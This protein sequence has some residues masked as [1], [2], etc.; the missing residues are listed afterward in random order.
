MISEEISKQA[1]KKLGSRLRKQQNSESKIL[2]NNDIKS[3]HEYRIWFKEPMSH[4]FKIVGDISS[5][6]YGSRVITY[7]IKRIESILSKLIRE[8]TMSLTKMGDIV[9]CRCIVNTEENVYKIVELIKQKFNIV[10]ERDYLK[11]PRQSGYQSY[12]LV[13]QLPEDWRTVEIQI[14]TDNNHNWATLLEITDLLYNVKVKEGATHKDLEKFHLLR[15]KKDMSI[16]EKLQFIELE[17]N[18]RVY[19]QLSKVIGSNYLNIR[20]EWFKLKQNKKDI[21]YIF[22]VNEENKTSILSFND[23]EDAENTYLNKFNN[24]KNNVVLTRL[25]KP[26][27]YNV[28]K[29]YSN[30]TFMRHQ[31]E[32]DFFAIVKDVI[33]YWKNYRTDIK[34]RNE[35]VKYLNHIIAQETD[36][37]ENEIENIDQS[38]IEDK[39]KIQEWVAELINRITVRRDLIQTINEALKPSIWDKILNSFSNL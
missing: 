28:S 32:D 15:S 26:N 9:G 36:F 35:Y 10:F 34:Q 31:F 5:D 25:E 18:L 39:E 30:Y 4:I 33:K 14:R 7:R 29:A 13:I 16:V 2:D 21:Y 6:V 17:K 19:E 1:I 27:F 3:L 11:T 8:P 23:F 22:E 38:K 12:H 20:L 24:S 37:L